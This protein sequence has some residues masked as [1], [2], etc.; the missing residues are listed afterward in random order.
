ML[1]TYRFE[2]AF[3]AEARVWYVAESNLCGLR[4]EASTLDELVAR[5]KVIV[6]D[7]LEAIAEAGGT[8]DGSHSVPLEVILHTQTLA[9][10]AAA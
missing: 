7:L 2:V 10:S 3:D 6:P 5:L 4:T 1:K 9:G 8:A